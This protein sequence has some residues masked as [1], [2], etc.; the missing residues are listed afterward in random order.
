MEFVMMLPA[1]PHHIIGLRVVVVM[2]MA[3]FV[4]TFLTRK[5]THESFLDCRL[6]TM[7]NVQFPLSLRVIHIARVFSVSTLPKFFNSFLCLAQLISLF[8]RDLCLHIM[9]ALPARTGIPTLLTGCNVERFNGQYLLAAKAPSIGALVLTPTPCS[10][11]SIPLCKDRSTSSAALHDF[12][13]FAFRAELF[14]RKCL[15]TSFASLLF[16][17][18]N[19]T[20]IDVLDQAVEVADHSR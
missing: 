6:K 9:Y 16:H 10:S 14:G 1:Q 3:L 7:A 20:T 19:S 2:T 17:N 5:F 18:Y 11:F 12:I 13:G 8:L 4:T 15:M